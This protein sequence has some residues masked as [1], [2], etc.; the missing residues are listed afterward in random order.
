MLKIKR[1]GILTSGGDSPGMNAAIRAVVRTGI[2]NDL[3]VYGIMSGY[4]G[5]IKNEIARMETSSVANI[6]Q[7]GGTILKSARSEDFKTKEGREKALNNLK[8]HKI[9]ALVVIGGD[10]TFTGADIFSR[11]HDIPMIGLPG[12]ID[13]DLYGTDFTIGYDTALNNVVMATD[14]IRDT[15]IAHNRLFLIE[16]MGRDA[17]FIA[18]RSG[19]AAG[20]EDILIPE[21]K[22][23]ISELIS[24]LKQSRRKNKMSGIIIVSEGDDAG[25]AYDIA[26]KIK[27]S[28]PEYEIR[29]TILGHIQRGGPPSCAD[30]VLA[31]RLGYEA[32]RAL[33][34]GRSGVMVGEIDNKIVYTPFE[35]AVKQHH[36]INKPLLEMAR[37]L[38]I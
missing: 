25:G 16:V 2:N 23:Y 11:E 37:V 21:T 32:V 10:G 24:K 3:E 13:N 15:A 5:L 9:D 34:K 14:K 26:D 20:A 36:K 29:V 35:N 27:E 38:S 28:Y 12:T 17:G 7:R 1:I 33:L 22:T 4:Q 30:R 19:I 6:I 31:S 8:K 18:L